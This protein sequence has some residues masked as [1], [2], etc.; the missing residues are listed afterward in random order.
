MRVLCVP[1]NFL[2]IVMILV[3]LQ[4][5]ILLVTGQGEVVCY[6][7]GGDPNAVM[8]N[9]DALVPLNFLNQPTQ[10]VKCSEIYDAGL[11]SLLFQ[12]E[13]DAAIADPLVQNT[14]GCSNASGGPTTGPPVATPS[15]TA[16]PGGTPAPVIGTPAP[17]IGTPAP[18]IG[19][20]APVIGTPA[21]VIATPAPIIATQAPITVST[22]VPTVTPGTT[23]P[24]PVVP[25]APVG[26]PPPQVAP[27]VR[28]PEAS[29]QRVPETQRQR[30]R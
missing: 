5:N 23:T 20:P 6:V 2:W 10:Q 29:S 16:A 8:N 11:Q 1:T 14:C 9:P 26:P 7:C 28:A 30:Q 18:V 15:V 4:N 17:V 21:P 19:T 13:C 27:S 22:L 25:T 24:A 12:N 3:F